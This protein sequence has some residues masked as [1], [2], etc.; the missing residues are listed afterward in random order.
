MVEDTSSAGLKQHALPPW[1]RLLAAEVLK[2]T[3]ALV[4]HECARVD[5]A[6]GIAIH[7][8][9]P[10]AVAHVRRG[11]GERVWQSAAKAESTAWANLLFASCERYNATLATDIL[12][13]PLLV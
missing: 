8:G 12:F 2:P 5:L 4:G 1:Q 10:G 6:N 3:A 9:P 7:T 13:T 11:A